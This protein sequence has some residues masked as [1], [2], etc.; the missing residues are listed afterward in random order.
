MQ[1]GHRVRSIRKDFPPS[2][3]ILMKGHRP[4]QQYTEEEAA[5]RA[6][7]IREGEVTILPSSQT[8]AASQQATDARI[9]SRFIAQSKTGLVSASVTS[10]R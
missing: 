6:R 5:S 8:T 2:R 4:K 1:P 10:P 7:D 3:Q 9:L